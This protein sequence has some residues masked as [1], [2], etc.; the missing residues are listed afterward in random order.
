MGQ[1]I[2]KITRSRKVP[3]LNWRWRLGLAVAFL[4]AAYLTASLA[5]DTGSLVAYGGTAILAWNGFRQL[6]AVRIKN[7]L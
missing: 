6:F 1:R 2:A 3:P 7:N 4:A 5:I